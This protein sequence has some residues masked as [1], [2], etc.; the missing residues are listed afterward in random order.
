MNG[1]KFLKNILTYFF[2]KY[3]S[4]MLMGGLTVTGTGFG[5]YIMGM[6]ALSPCPLL[7][8]HE[9]GAALMVRLLPVT[10]L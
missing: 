9:L 3:R 5:A 6:A 4:L 10:W 7:I 2:F 8:H 1:C